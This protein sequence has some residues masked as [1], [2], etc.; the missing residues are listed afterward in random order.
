MLLKEFEAHANSSGRDSIGLN[1]VANFRASKIN[2]SDCLKSLTARFREGSNEKYLLSAILSQP[3]IW[4]RIESRAARG[5][6]HIP[7]G[8]LR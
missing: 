7:R 4:T 1:T 8:R 3:H 2:P 5:R 6:E